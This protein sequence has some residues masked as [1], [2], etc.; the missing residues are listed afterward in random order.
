MIWQLVCWCGGN[1]CG[2]GGG[3]LTAHVFFSFLPREALWPRCCMKSNKDSVMTQATCWAG[4]STWFSATCFSCRLLF[5][6]W[7]SLVWCIFVG[8]NSD[9][10][11]SA[12]GEVKLWKCMFGFSLKYPVIGI[13]PGVAEN[14]EPCPGPLEFNLHGF[15]KGNFSNVLPGCFYWDFIR[16]FKSVA[17]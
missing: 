2:G 15:T 12:H 10:D 5:L 6:P 9:A 1:I 16:W 14:L 4:M 8:F 11:N 17:V 7:E 13:I 3:G